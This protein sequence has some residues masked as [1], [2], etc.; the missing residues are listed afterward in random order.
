[1]ISVCLRLPEGRSCNKPLSTVGLS[2]NSFFL[3]H[4]Q[5]DEMSHQINQQAQKR[6]FAHAV[7]FKPHRN[8]ARLT[9]VAASCNDHVR[10]SPKASKPHD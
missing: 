8:L 5:P 10:L 3:F 7:I 6:R 9:Q 1:M 4:L 2:T